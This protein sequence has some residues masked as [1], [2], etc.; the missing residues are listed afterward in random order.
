VKLQKEKFLG[1]EFLVRQKQEGVRRK[2]VGLE[3]LENAIPRTGYQVTSR[4]REIGRVTS[5]TFSPSLKKGLAMA[6][7]PVEASKPG[8]EV[9]VVVRGKE[10]RAV[11]TK[12]PFYRKGSRK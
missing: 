2:L 9:T 11:V 4:G 1:R 12:L 5:G 8:T 7:L 10:H 3:M 6:Y